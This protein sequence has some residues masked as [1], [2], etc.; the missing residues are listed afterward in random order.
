MVTSETEL[1]KPE[2]GKTYLE[3]LGGSIVYAYG[4]G[5]NATVTGSTVICVDN[6]SRVVNSIIDAS[7]PNAGTG[8]ELLTTDRFRNQMGINTGLSYPSSDAFQIGRFF[9]GNNQAPMAI[10]PEWNLISG[11]IRNLYSG[12]NQGAMVADK[13]LFLPIRSDGMKIDNVY[14]GCRMADV[15]PDKHSFPEE[16]FSDGIHLPGGYAACVLV[17]GGD[18]NNVYGGN[19]ISGKVYGGSLVGIHSSIKGDVSG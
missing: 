5:N 10:R 3:I 4:G 11:L 16:T 1:T 14:G 17:E 18:I 15:N 13:C 12:G 7:N 2:L 19:D 9:G 6:P 8:G